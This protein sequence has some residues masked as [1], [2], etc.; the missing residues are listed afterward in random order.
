[1]LSTHYTYLKISVFQ[2]IL[3]ATKLIHWNLNKTANYKED[4]TQVFNKNYRFL[5]NLVFEKQKY[6]IDSY[7]KERKWSFS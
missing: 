3:K 4:I 2:I 1:M 5:T 7:I 6:L